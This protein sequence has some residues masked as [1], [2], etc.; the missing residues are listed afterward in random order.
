[1]TV[2]SLVFCPENSG[3]LGLSKL[4]FLSLQPIESSFPELCLGSPTLL[5]IPETASTQK[6]GVQSDLI[7]FSSLSSELRVVQSLKTAVW[8]SVFEDS[9]ICSSQ[10]CKPLVTH[11]RVLLVIFDCRFVIFGHQ[12]QGSPLGTP[13]PREDLYLVGSQRGTSDLEPSP[14]DPLKN[15][16][17]NLGAPASAPP[18]CRWLPLVLPI[19]IFTFRSISPLGFSFLWFFPPYLNSL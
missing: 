16:R 11:I 17:L 7:C 6:I 12:S 19:S 13:S 2:F 3:H 8:L 9:N 15:L 1:M 5:C 14:A 10:A 18:A 4:Q